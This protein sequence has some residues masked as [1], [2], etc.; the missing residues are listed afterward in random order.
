M[1]DNM[2]PAVIDLRHLISRLDHHPA[3]RIAELLPWN[4]KL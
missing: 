3:K 4:V 1:T 2:S